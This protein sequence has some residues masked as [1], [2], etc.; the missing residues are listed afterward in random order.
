MY[1]LVILGDATLRAFPVSRLIFAKVKQNRAIIVERGCSFL[2]SPMFFKHSVAINWV[3]KVKPY[4][5]L[6]SAK[7]ICSRPWEER[8]VVHRLHTCLHHY[9]NGVPNAYRACILTLPSLQSLRFSHR[10]E[11]DTRVSGDEAQWTTGRRKSR[12]PYRPFQLERRLDRRQ[13]TYVFVTCHVFKVEFTVQSKQLPGSFFST[14]S[15]TMWEKTFD[16]TVLF[17]TINSASL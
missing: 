5:G 16:L 4:R 15:S 2:F 1:S 3:C 7:E 12:A 6:A 10:G 17:E 14:T 9:L 11:R 13:H 8:V